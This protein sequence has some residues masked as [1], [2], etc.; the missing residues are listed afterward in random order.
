LA[1]ACVWRERKKNEAIGEI[2]KRFH[3]EGLERLYPRELSGG[4]QQRTALARIVACGPDVILLDEPFSA[5]DSYLREQVQMETGEILKGYDNS[6]MVT[7]SRDEAYRLCGELLVMDGGK[8][9]ISGKTR[10]LFKQ[11]RIMQAAKLTGCKN[12]SKAERVGEHTVRALDWGGL[13]LDTNE[14]VDGPVH[15]VG[16]RAHDFTPVFEDSGHRNNTMR[17]NIISQTESPFEK[18]VL[19]NNADAAAS[20]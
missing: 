17:I 13:P 15:F 16:I 12:I 4:Q 7:H 20:G 6:I 8:I 14:P 11:P 2:V 1:A 9:L 18:H 5:L 3:L 19:F 10:E